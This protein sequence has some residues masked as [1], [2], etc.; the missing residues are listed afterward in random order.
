MNATAVVQLNIGYSE[1]D[2]EYFA[3]HDPKT[4]F[5]THNDNEILKACIF[6]V[7]PSEVVEFRRQDPIIKN[8]QDR[9]IATKVPARWLSE[10][11]ESPNYL[12]KEKASEVASHLYREYK[13]FPE[14]IGASAEGG[15][16]LH[17]VNYDNGKTLSVDIDNELEI[18]AIVNQHK[19]IIKS[20]DIFNMDFLDIVRAYAS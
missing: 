7:R 16:M 5:S 15:V 9:V 8:L 10:G 14:R 17:Y 12:C 13:Y 18:A 20:A 6:K 11:I 1:P 2:A 3:Y 19:T 4:K